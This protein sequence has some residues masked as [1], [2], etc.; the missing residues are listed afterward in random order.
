M[1]DD[2]N[3]RPM[4]RQ[5]SSSSLAP[6]PS[7][8]LL[9]SLPSLLIHPPSHRLHLQSVALSQHALRRCLALP[10]LDHDVECRAWTALAELGLG[11]LEDGMKN[12]EGEVEKALTKALL[13]ANK[14]PSLRPYAPHIMMLS[15]RLSHHQRN[16]KFAHHTL[17]R[18]LSSFF[19]PSDPPH[20]L[21]SAHLA[22]VHSY[23]TE[24]ES[25]NS[26][27]QS[28]TKCL[29]G[30]QDLHSC[31]VS[32]S[33]SLVSLLALLIRLQLLVRHGLFE[34]VA[35]AL[36]A[37][38]KG[39]E[40]YATAPNAPDSI[41]TSKS[42]I[43]SPMQIHLLIVGVLYHT[44]AGDAGAAAER[45]RTLHALLDSGALNPGGDGIM[46]I[47]FPSPLHTQPLRITATHPRVLYILVFLL[48]AVSKRDPVGRKPKKGVF[49]REGLA[50]LARECATPT[51]SASS[52]SASGSGSAS[53][54]AGKEITL[55]VYSSLS[56]LAYVRT[57]IEK[58]RADLMCEV[59]SISIMR[60]DFDE[61][62]RTINTLTAHTRTHALWSTYAARITLQH[63]QLAHARGAPERALQCYRVAAYVAA[64][65]GGHGEKDEWVRVAARAGE[66]WVRIGMLRR[67]GGRRDGMDLDGT[68]KPEDT[69]EEEGEKELEELRKYGE[70]VA[71]ECEGMGG[72]LRA[73]AHLLRACLGTEFLGAKHHLRRAL[74][75]ATAAQDNHLRAL[76]L[77]L[78]ASHYLH[79]AREHAGTMLSTCEQL[80][81]GLGAVER[82]GNAGMGDKGDKGSGK[83]KGEPLGNV[84]LRLWVGERFLELHRWAGDAQKVERQ[85]AVNERLRRALEARRS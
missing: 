48:S 1:S 32:A 70:E 63:A 37:A 65:E 78:S 56:E 54:S 5:R 35:D 58:L 60:S 55:P 80:A 11:C 85:V 28:L 29:G 41:A 44:Y 72:N 15:A 27:P 7:S 18:L 76:V 45:L 82:K 84:P 23:A 17:R 51:G 30:V 75:L 67:A 36:A 4:K 46:E 71:G 69:G 42:S 25:S 64:G 2:A 40:D 34:Q 39:F 73:V 38:E 3:P 13:I 53:P 10:D 20:M 77:A 31:S 12:V 81:A 14:H 68:V 16:A 59:V 57:R 52:S 21:Y 49:A 79:T 83:E 9:L 24:A 50:V 66:V 19:A 61:A 62:E 43:P 74:D 22:L 6:L 33:S 8:K 26:N 47:P